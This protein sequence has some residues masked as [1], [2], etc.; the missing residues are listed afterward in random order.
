MK[1]VRKSGR[2]RAFDILR[3]SQELNNNTIVRRIACG[4]DEAPLFKIEISIHWYSGRVQTFDIL[5]SSWE[6]NSTIAR[7]PACDA[8]EG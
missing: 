2:L 8:D 4:A 6:L 7:R 3:S 5:G 1:G